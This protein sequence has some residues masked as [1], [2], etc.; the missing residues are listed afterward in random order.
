MVLPVQVSGTDSNGKPFNYLAYTLDIGSGGARL[1]GIRA[2]LNIGGV[3][4]VQYKQK[5]ARFEVKWIGR[6]GTPTE[7]LVG[8]AYLSGEKYIWL[9]LPKD[10]Y[11]D[12]YQLPAGEG[13]K[14]RRT[15]SRYPCTGSV[16]ILGA[17]DDDPPQHGQLSNISLM[18]CVV[19]MKAAQ[20]V[21]SRRKLQI[22]ARNREFVAWGVVRRVHSG[23]VGLQFVKIDAGDRQQ[24]EL[25][26]QELADGEAALGTPGS[27]L[28][29]RLR[30]AEEDLREI[31]ELLKS[32]DVDP[33]VLKHF[34]GVLGQVRHTAWAVQQWLKLQQKS[35]EPFPVLSYI[36]AARVQL[37]TQLC[38]DMGHHMEGFDV[39]LPDE[40]VQALLSATEELAQRLRKAGFQ[41]GSKGAKLSA[42]GAATDATPEIKAVEREI[43]A[44]SANIEDALNLIAQRACSLTSADG[45][46]IA[47]GNRDRLV[48]RAS[49]G[50]APAVGLS[51]PADSG[52][53]GVSLR[54]G[55]VVV[56][57]DAENDPRMDAAVCR[58]L[59][60]R[61]A[62]IAPFRQGESI[63]GLLQVHS[64]KANVFE[65]RHTFMLQR[66]VELIRQA[67]TSY[68][69]ASQQPVT[70]ED[71]GATV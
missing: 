58:A 17:H 65:T 71:S 16:T 24:L 57:Q 13:G 19:C 10:D 26:V 34:R 29:E 7:G 1:G 66:L 49:A 42:P 38:K 23:T 5:K 21:N 36:N 27:L 14:D 44:Q 20:P 54:T 2:L 31:E 68:A 8:I 12:E 4:S 46:A 9:E 47:I 52:L 32:V 63:L 33:P 55:Q 25:L 53:P 15:N 11:Q 30:K 37:L 39:K 22:K 40:E 62:V 60:L 45:A 18:G 59:N 3:I 41:N 56:Y 67:V 28:S 51:L 69:A 43:R 48:C 6:P 61:S 70:L 35:G 64:A 50:F